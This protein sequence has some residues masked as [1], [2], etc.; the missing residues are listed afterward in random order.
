MNTTHNRTPKN[1]EEEIISLLGTQPVNMI[2][3]QFN[4]SKPTI[5]RIARD[6]N[7]ST[8]YRKYS[9]NTS[10]FHTIDDEHKAYWLGFILADG[11]VSKPGKTHI[12]N[13]R[14]KIN[15]SNKDIYLLE[16][17]KK[18]IEAFNSHIHTYIP[19]KTF[20]KNPMSEIILNSKEL[21]NDLKQY[22]IDSYKTGNESIPNNIPEDLIRHFIRGY[23]DGDGT[24][25]NNKDKPTISFTCANINF[26]YQ[27]KSLL[28]NEMN[29]LS[30]A[31]PIPSG[32]QN[33]RIKRSY[34]IS[35]GGIIDV[36]NFYNYIYKNA[37]IYL[38]RKYNKYTM[39][40]S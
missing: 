2:V 39:L 33:S 26:L 11:C 4:I 13:C 36:L 21:C 12:D 30:N 22:G 28:Q 32:K 10:Y 5:Y 14:L 1:I 3:N 37:T 8:T 24:I 20:S 27:L 18:D 34:Q 9:F 7:V 23:F 29:L 16:M 25:T 19:E 17:F 6:Y 40:L 35:F 38:P 15:I 31:I